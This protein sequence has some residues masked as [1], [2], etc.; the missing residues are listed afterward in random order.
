MVCKHVEVCRHHKNSRNDH[1]FKKKFHFV[2]CPCLCFFQLSSPVIKLNSKSS[3]PNLRT[4]Q[5]QSLNPQSE[6][7]CPPGV[8]AHSLPGNLHPAV[9]P[10][11]AAAAA[12]AGN[13]HRQSVRSKANNP[14]E[15]VPRTSESAHRLMSCNF[16]TSDNLQTRLLRTTTDEK[17]K[18]YYR[19]SFTNFPRKGKC[20]AFR[21]TFQADVRTRGGQLWSVIIRQR[22]SVSLNPLCAKWLSNQLHAKQRRF[23]PNE[24]GFLQR[25]EFEKR[26]LFE[27]MKSLGVVNC[28]AVITACRNRSVNGNRKVKQWDRK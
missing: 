24:K 7:S 12:A 17:R 9:P 8:F 23:F 1:S 4:F 11:A 14:R 3:A 21:G 6:E 5:A 20:H 25:N 22:S 18:L 16:Y 13:Q 19:T 10:A 26:V 15:A 28:A 2:S 27:V